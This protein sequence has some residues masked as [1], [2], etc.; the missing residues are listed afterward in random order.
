MSEWLQFDYN[1]PP[2]GVCWLNVERPETWCDADY[3]GRSIG[4]YTGKT[5]RVVVL[6]EVYCGENG[7]TTFESV[8]GEEFGAVRDDDVVLS[9]MR[10]TPPKAT[11]D[12]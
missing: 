5:E 10:L 6:A 9:F 12:V 1:T 3:D 2:E 4:G 11:N 7:I 8:L